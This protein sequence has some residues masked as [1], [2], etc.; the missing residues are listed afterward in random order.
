MNKTFAILTALLLV[1]PA[2]HAAPSDS[3][4][5][6]ELEH[7]VNVLTEQVNRLLAER[8]G[9]RSDDPN[10]PRRKHQSGQGAFGRYPPMPR[11]AQRNVLQRRR[12][13][14][15][16]LPLAFSGSLKPQKAACTLR[17]P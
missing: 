12:R 3:E 7:R 4:R 5:I 15:P 6:A 9:R 1:Q 11:G 16:N 13:V 2:A 8:H 10:L 17:S 14:L